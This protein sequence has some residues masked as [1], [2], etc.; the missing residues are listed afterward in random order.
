MK[1]NEDDIKKRGEFISLSLSDNK[2]AAARLSQQAKSLAN[3]R[4]TTDTVRVLKEILYISEA[5]IFRDI[6]KY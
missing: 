3:A 5:T 1:K 2:A 4:N 6:S